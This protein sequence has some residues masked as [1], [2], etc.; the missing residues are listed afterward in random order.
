MA[1]ISCSANQQ[2]ALMYTET[3]TIEA[4]LAKLKELSQYIVITM[5]ADGALFPIVVKPLLCR[6]VL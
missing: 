1:L 2:E 4:A 6:A 3:D 5:S